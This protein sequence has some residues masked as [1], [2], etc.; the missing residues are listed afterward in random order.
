MSYAFAPLS[1]PAPVYALPRELPWAAFARTLERA[2][3]GLARLDER[4]RN[5]AL[6]EGWIA[7]GISARP[8]PPSTSRAS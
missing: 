7:R 1:A 2:E 3:E 6:A 5:N 8:V 4:L